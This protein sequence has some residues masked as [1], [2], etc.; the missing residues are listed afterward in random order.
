MKTAANVPR[1]C[2][3]PSDDLNAEWRMLSVLHSAFSLRHQLHLSASEIRPMKPQSG[4]YP[5]V[6]RQMLAF[7]RHARVNML[8]YAGPLLGPATMNPVAITLKAAS[9]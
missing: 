6:D 7:E 3:L 4:F 5:L 9:Q 1:S 2:G 8:L